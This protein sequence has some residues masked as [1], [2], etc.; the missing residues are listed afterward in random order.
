MTDWLK[1]SSL[2]RDP[3]LRTPDG[4]AAAWDDAVV[5][6]IDAAGNFSA[7]NGRSRA[8]TDPGDRRRDDIYLGRQGDRAWFARPVF[9]IEGESLGWRDVDPA[10]AEPLAAA[11]VLGRWHL[12]SPACE[13]CGEATA[14]D[15]VGAR[16]TCVGCGAWAFPRTDPC[17]IVAITDAD[18][19]LL[20]ARQA[21]WPENRFSI[22][23][24]F[25]EAGES[26]EQ[27][28]HREV[29]EEVGVR[30]TELAYAGSQPWP[31]PRSLMLGFTARTD[32]TQ[33]TPDGEEIVDASFRSRA[34]V[35]A[36]I[37]AGRLILPPS[38]SIA[39]RL[40]DEWFDRSPEA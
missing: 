22:V 13:R 1:T 4:A 33:A 7:A 18:D 9:E 14:P 32:A 10:E 15:L 30:L 24:G 38:A 3:A 26:A 39:R 11:V 29:A 36:H 35:R 17:V 23:A 20:L 34:E 37:E 40:I 27:A 31:M 28:C 8:I 19:R 6:E 21:S 25:I 16:R 2:D 12:Q 5:V